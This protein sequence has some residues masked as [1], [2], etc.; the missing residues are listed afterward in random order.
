MITSQ[1]ATEGV[2]RYEHLISNPKTRGLSLGIWCTY[3][4]H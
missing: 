4:L 1:E 2:E 3:F